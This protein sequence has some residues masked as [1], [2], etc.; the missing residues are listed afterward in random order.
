MFPEARKALGRP[1]DDVGDRML[2]LKEQMMK[3]TAT[4]RR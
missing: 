3:T 1:A 2:E 4:S